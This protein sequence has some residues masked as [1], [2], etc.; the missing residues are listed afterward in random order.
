MYSQALEITHKAYATLAKYKQVAERFQFGRRRPN[1]TW[2]HHREAAEKFQFSARAKHLSWEHHREA[3]KKF[4]FPRRRGNLSLAHHREVCGGRTPLGCIR[5]RE[6][7]TPAET[8]QICVLS[9]PA[10]AVDV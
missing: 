3:A 2:G 5:A 6:T 1:L 9:F 10:R 4:H 8:T 7:N